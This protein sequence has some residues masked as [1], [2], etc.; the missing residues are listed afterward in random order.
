MCVL[1]AYQGEWNVCYILSSY[2]THLFCLAYVKALGQSDSWSIWTK[3]SSGVGASGCV[4]L[5]SLA[6]NSALLT[7][8][9]SADR[10]CSYKKLKKKLHRNR[11]AEWTRI[12]EVINNSL[13]F[14]WPRRIVRCT[15]LRLLPRAAAIASAVCTELSLNLKWTLRLNNNCHLHRCRRRHHLLRHHCSY[16]ILPVCVRQVCTL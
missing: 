15:F 3:L 10:F 13:Y 14:R 8:L 2:Q 16:S 9:T 11:R 12:T 1:W 6:R 4:P 5:S 7:V